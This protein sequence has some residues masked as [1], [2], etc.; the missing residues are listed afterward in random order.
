MQNI[1]HTNRNKKRKTSK[2]STPAKQAAGH[3]AFLSQI[4]IL[5]LIN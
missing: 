4:A 1:T 3:E 2:Y 5:N